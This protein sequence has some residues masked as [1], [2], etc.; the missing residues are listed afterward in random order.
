MREL[1]LVGAD[2]QGDGRV[3]AALRACL[4]EVL[5]DPGRNSRK[6]CAPLCAA[7]LIPRSPSKSA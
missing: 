1:D 7:F 3:G 6:R 5:D 4:E 2:F